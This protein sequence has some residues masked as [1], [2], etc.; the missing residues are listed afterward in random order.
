MNIVTDMNIVQ[1]PEPTFVSP[2][3]K[4]P[5]GLNQIDI[6][7]TARPNITINTDSG[8]PCKVTEITSTSPSSW[9]VTYIIPAPPLTKKVRITAETLGKT[10]MKEIQCTKKLAIGT[11]VVRGPDWRKGDKDGGP[12]SVGIVTD[13][14]WSVVFVKWGNEPGYT[15]DRFNNLGFFD[16]RTKI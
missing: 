12:G 7:A 13:Y 14:V 11:R 6:L 8:E 9:H 16:V 4:V 5:H 3:E 10:V 1:L 15:S 2:P